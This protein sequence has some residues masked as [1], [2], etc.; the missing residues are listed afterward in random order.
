M[1]REKLKGGFE[2]D[3][4]SRRYVRLFTWPPRIRKSAKRKFW[5][6]QRK[7]AKLKSIRE[8]RGNLSE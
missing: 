2:T 4:L 5:K 6:R 7:A 8:A 1:A 3:C